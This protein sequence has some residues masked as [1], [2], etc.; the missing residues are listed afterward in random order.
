MRVNRYR[1][2]SYEEFGADF[3]AYIA[4]MNDMTEGK[5]LPPGYVPQTTYWFVDGGK[6]VGSVSI[7]HRLNEKLL[8]TGGH[9]GY[10]IRPSERSK[11]YGTAI[12]KMALPK[13][14]ELGITNVLLTCNEANIG[15]RKIIEANGGILENKVSNPEGGPDKLRFWIDL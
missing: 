2:F 5:N 8:Q 13:A 9:I 7:R 12:L 3:P 1:E 4:K 6:F 14:R 15:S 10:D 11:G